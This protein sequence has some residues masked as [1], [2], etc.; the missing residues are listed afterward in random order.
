M[1]GANS[2][3]LSNAVTGPGASADSKPADPS[4]P[5]AGPPLP[6]AL[7]PVQQGELPY[8]RLGTDGSTV[9]PF[10]D[11]DILEALV[12]SGASRDAAPRTLSREGT[13]TA[14]GWVTGDLDHAFS[15]V[16]ELGANVLVAACGIPRRSANEFLNRAVALLDVH[17]ID[18]E[19]PV[20][21]AAREV[22]EHPT[23]H[24]EVDAADSSDDEDEDEDRR[25]G[26]DRPGHP[27]RVAGHSAGVLESDSLEGAEALTE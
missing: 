11:T 2:S 12:T 24:P 4:Q 15:V 5:K 21:P 1:R 8:D 22:L 10:T 9:R 14:L 6:L 18:A 26:D 7:R 19:S 20:F 3:Q 27:R 23:F 25:D 16:A 13:F 17:G